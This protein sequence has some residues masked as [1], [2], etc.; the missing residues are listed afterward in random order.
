MVVLQAELLISSHEST[1]SVYRNQM[2]Y[3]RLACWSVCMRILDCVL[4]S[5][6][7]CLVSVPRVPFPLFDHFVSFAY[8]HGHTGGSD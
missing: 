3:I 5:K 4:E 1:S 8:F 6:S 2:M 7:R